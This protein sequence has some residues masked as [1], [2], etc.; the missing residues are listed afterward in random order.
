ML[1]VI[2]INGGCSRCNGKEYNAAAIGFFKNEHQKMYYVGQGPTICLKIS[3]RLHETVD[4]WL[5]SFQQ[6]ISSW[7]K[8]QIDKGFNNPLAAMVKF[9]QVLPA[10]MHMLK[11]DPANLPQ[12]CFGKLRDGSVFGR[13]QGCSVY[14][15]V[16]PIGFGKKHVFR[17]KGFY[18]ESR[19]LAPKAGAVEGE[20]EG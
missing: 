8:L 6:V 1:C 13:I 20:I 14:N 16:I 5:N 11:H 4:I 9:G 15:T 3:G 12:P 18:M 17:P 2:V 10:L 19:H 7:A